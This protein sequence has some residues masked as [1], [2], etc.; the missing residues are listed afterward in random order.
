LRRLGVSVRK[1]VKME[2]LR[3][4]V[5]VRNAVKPLPKSDDPDDPDEPYAMITAPTR[6]RFPRRSGSVAIDPYEY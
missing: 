6:P 5:Q 2:A 3:I 4:W 1:A